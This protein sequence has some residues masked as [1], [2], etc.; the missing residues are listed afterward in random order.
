MKESNIHVGNATIEQ[1]QRGILLN[2]KGQ[3]M[4][5]S[6]IHVSNVTIK[7]HQKEILL[8]TKGQCMNEF[9]FHAGIVLRNL[10]PGIILQ[11]TKDIYIYDSPSSKKF[12]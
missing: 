12:V 4:K 10:L 3:Y 9:D 2:T 7:Q 5:V 8:N 1:H 6:N 11:S